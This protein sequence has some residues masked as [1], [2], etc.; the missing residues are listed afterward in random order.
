MRNT[1]EKDLIFFLESE[2]LKQAKIIIK[3]DIFDY[4]NFYLSVQNGINKCYHDKYS[5]IDIEIKFNNI[6]SITLEELNIDNVLGIRYEDNN[7][8]IGIR[9]VKRNGIRYDIILSGVN[10]TDKLKNEIDKLNRSNQ[11]LFIMALGKLM[12]GDYLIA[13]HLAHTLCM[14]TLVNQMIK[15]DKEKGINIHRYGYRETLEYFKLYKKIDNCKYCIG[16]ENYNHIVKELISNIENLDNFTKQ[17]KEDIFHIWDN[18]I[19]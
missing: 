15:R 7:E 14:E 8:N 11:F 13:D 3:D 2:F 16:D 17:D 18:Y 5:D 10:N 19:K 6:D 12:R 4:N 1:I 9:L